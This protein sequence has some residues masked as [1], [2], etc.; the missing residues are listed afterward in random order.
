MDFVESTMVGSALYLTQALLT[1]PTRVWLV[2]QGAQS[3]D[4]HPTDAV[5]STLW[6]LGKVIALEHPELNP[7]CLDLDP[8]DSDLEDI[9]ALL[10]MADGE[11]QIALRNHTRYAMR[12][13]RYS[14]PPT[15]ED[16]PKQ[17]VITER[18]V[19]DNL[20]FAPLARHKPG[21]KQ[22]EICVRATG[23]NF[24]DVLNVMGMY[25]GD[26]GPLGGECA[27]E[28]VAVG[29]EV[30]G[31]QVGDAVLALASGSFSSHIVTNADLVVH[32]PDN[33]TFEQAATLAIPFI[34]AYYCL[35]HLGDMQ[36]G[37]RVL[38]HAAAGG[39]GLAAVQL[40]QRIGAEIF[41]T[42]GSPEKREFLESIGVQH[43][44][45]SRTLDFADAIL[46]ITGGQGVD[47]VLNSLAD[48]F[49]PASLS[50]LAQGGR[51]LEIGK[52]GIL[53]EADFAQERP[54]AHY[55]IIDWT[56]EA[57]QNAPL[58]RSILLEV[59]AWI[60]DGTLNT[61]PVQVFPLADAS[62]AFRYMAQAKHIG[63]IALSHYETG[64]VRPDA[65]YLITGGLSGLGLLVAQW[66]VEKGAR[67]LALMGRRVPSDEAVELLDSLRSTGAQIAVIQG[68]VSIESGYAISVHSDRS[69]NAPPARNYPQCW[70]AVGCRLASTELGTP[71]HSFRSKGQWYMAATSFD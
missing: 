50:V 67:H 44:L 66:L 10:R 5:Q 58:I 26:P 29:S 33:L 38:I 32:K 40:A 8:A 7:V 14:M 16:R 13:E 43:V 69:G 36:P 6:G 21:P 2:T 3:L 63:K 62:A 52:R 60:E 30:E 27:G 46:D 48:E 11:D 45:N 39:V 49:V 23:L 22:V 20:A 24:K 9:V 1:Y 42:A 59:L 37:E 61:L 68:D 35:H 54:D 56:P 51:F 18:G 57:N 65:T 12:L 64:T 47:L 19:I 15:E 17:L 41:A 34:T 55:S 71:C 31:L 25:P 53:S 70:C 28:V 4:E